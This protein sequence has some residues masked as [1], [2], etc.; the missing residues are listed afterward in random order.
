MRSTSHLL[1]LATLTLTA[2]G[3]CGDTDK[4]DTDDTDT[5]VIVDT[6]DTN[7][8]DTDVIVD[9]D[10]TDTDDTD[11]DDTDVTDDTDDTDVI[12]DTDVNTEVGQAEL[13][14]GVESL[15]ASDSTSALDPFYAAKKHQYLYTAADLVAAGVPTDAV[16]THIAILTAEQPGSSLFGFRLAALQTTLTSVTGFIESGDLPEVVYGPTTVAQSDFTVDAWTTFLLDTTIPWDGTSNLV[17]EISLDDDADAAGNGGGLYQ[18]ST[19]TTGRHAGGYTHSPA[20][21]PFLG[22]NTII[23]DGNVAALTLTYTYVP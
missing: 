22:I 1:L 21:Y 2:M 19:G 7:D 23:D 13:N 18:R 14:T 17:L 9:T 11:V 20:D 8:T 5:D 10:G 12:V 16:I 6:D 15:A 3:G 4:E